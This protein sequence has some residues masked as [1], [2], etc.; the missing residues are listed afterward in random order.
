MT[1]GRNADRSALVCRVGS[2][3]GALPGVFDLLLP[4][5]DEAF[6]RR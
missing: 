6:G 3:C 1:N 2:Q 5:L 4:E